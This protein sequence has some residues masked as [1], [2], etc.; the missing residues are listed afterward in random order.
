MDVAANQETTVQDAV[1]SF[2]SV[3][4]LDIFNKTLAHFPAMFVATNP[5]T[6]VLREEDDHPPP[7]CTH[8]PNKC[9]QCALSDAPVVDKT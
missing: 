9:C 5:N 8:V 2:I 7:W 1:S 6:G 4:L 3:N